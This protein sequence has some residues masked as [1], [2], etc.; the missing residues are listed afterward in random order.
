MRVT[1]SS[2]LR[3]CA[4][5]APSSASAHGAE[6]VDVDQPMVVAVPPLLEQDRAGAVELDRRG[7]SEHQRG[8]QDEAEA[9]SK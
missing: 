3:A 9:P 4:T 8:E 2:S 6:L 7:N 1:R 5:T